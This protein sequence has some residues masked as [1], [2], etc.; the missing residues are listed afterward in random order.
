MV[1]YTGKSVPGFTRYITERTRD[2]IGRE[3][4]FQ[5]V[6]DWLA[7]SDAPRYFIV[8]GEPG[9]G[10]TAIAAR[11]TQLHELAA[12][13]F[14]VTRQA[15]TLD[16]LN[17]ARSISH[18]LAHLDG[19]ARY[20]LE[21]A[22]IHV[23]ASI[24]VQKN[25][26][27][28]LGVRI[29]RLIT[30]SAMGS[31]A[32]IRT[33]VAPLKQLYADGFEQQLVIL[34]DAL[35][36]AVQYQGSE[37]IVDL[38]ASSEGLPPNIRFVLTSR[39]DSAALRHFEEQHIPYLVI[40]AERNENLLDARRFIIS[41][42]SKLEALQVRL[43][44]E[45]VPPQ[46][47]IEKVLHTSNGNFLYLVWT[48]SAVAAGT[49]QLDSLDILPEGLDGIYREFLRTRMAGKDVHQW[50][51]HYRPIL[52]IL[53]A[54]QTPLTIEQLVQFTG[55]DKQAVKDT[56]Q[57]I[58]Q[59]LDPTLGRRKRY[60]LYH[61]SMTDFMSREERAHE[62]WVELETIHRMIATYYREHFTHRWLACDPYGLRYLS[63]HL[64]EARQF[65]VLRKLLLDPGWL[66]AQRSY[67]PALQIYIQSV[68][69]VLEIAE[70][71]E[72]EGLPDVVA[73]SLL[74]GT[75]I[76]QAD[77]L[78]LTAIEA[79]VGLGEIEQALHYA[80][81]LTEP[82]RKANA[83][84]TIGTQLQVQGLALLAREV[85]THAQVAAKSIQRDGWR[86]RTLS[87]VAQALHRLGEKEQAQQ[88]KVEALAVAEHIQ[89]ARWRI[90]I[91]NYM[92]QD[93]ATLGDSD[94]AQKILRQILAEAKA[95]SGF[96]PLNLVLQTMDQI[97]NEER[98]DQ[99]IKDVLSQLDATE[100]VQ[101]FV[102]GARLIAHALIKIGRVE[103]AAEILDRAII[104]VKDDEDQDR[105]YLVATLAAMHAYDRALLL[106]EDIKAEREHALALRS[107]AISLA[108]NGD[109]DR[110]LT[111]AKSI[112]EDWAHAE[113]LSEIAQALAKAGI[114]ERA[115]AVVETIKDEQ[116]CAQALGYI[117]LTLVKKKEVNQARDVLARTRSM[118]K[119]SDDRVHQSQ[120]LSEI[121]LALAKDVEKALQIWSQSLLVASSINYE[122]YRIKVLSNIALAMNEAG[123][124]DKALQV[125][126]EA[127]KDVEDV[128]KEFQSSALS[129]VAGHQ[130]LIGEREQAH[131]AIDRALQIAEAMQSGFECVRALNDAADYLIKLGEVEQARG[132][133]YKALSVARRIRGRGHRA[134]ALSEVSAVLITMGEV[135][136]A[137]QILAESLPLAKG[138]DRPL[139]H[140]ALGFAQIGEVDRALAVA[141]EVSDKHEASIALRGVVQTLLREGILD[142]ASAVA[143]SMLDDSFGNH[144]HA[145]CDIARYL[146]K[147]KNI[148][149]ARQVLAQALTAAENIEIEDWRPGALKDVSQ[150]LVQILQPEDR[151]IICLM[152]TAFRTARH[153]G[154]TE[155][156]LHV[157]AF[158]KVLGK[159]GVIEAVWAHI[160]EVEAL[161][162]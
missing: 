48:L 115:L 73:W 113:A 142:Q 77:S 108:K 121:A 56:V 134:W 156:W 7:D 53:A 9:I 132:V 69:R 55:L 110:A 5:A 99:V 24:A 141:S 88:A 13:H 22:A 19:F 112:K 84:L 111:L 159:L 45:G 33:V 35:D 140:V 160:Q 92:A 101:R 83:Y 116:R 124:T 82:M 96:L 128:N 3:W 137:R 29:E 131:Q 117:A 149:H 91:M 133:L 114:F 14:C 155:V 123:I 6:N 67:D 16:P 43:A 97:E 51:S 32:F 90:E 127:Y 47:F 102:T 65:G 15:D 39:R 23:E 138:D 8:T 89:D 146:I 63:T 162:K 34:V 125:M 41:Q 17:F 10:K 143:N 18:Q 31:V 95:L 20:L 152:M 144:T 57:D 54:A 1:Q 61:Q 107:I 150:G 126:G 74:Y 64:I 80:D 122:W 37:T 161:W 50:R 25:Y 147:A 145:L 94:L 119:D 30:A 75:V 12:V 58:E 71:Q 154:R 4:V 76:S 153:R 103:Q 118:I 49:Q 105:E 36:E 87:K 60:Q 158:T 79:M 157:E 129:T 44:E 78:P 136:Q 98:I 42:I 62:F 72:L 28:I 40:D 81:V 59:F 109:F 93:L 68:E 21:E 85:L 66:D 135:E 38:L 52:G 70:T 46:A 86:A 130:A 27:Q 120:A 104:L 151:E 11:L 106:A 26:G 100:D 139:S 2:F 148:K